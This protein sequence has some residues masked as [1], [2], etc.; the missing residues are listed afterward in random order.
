MPMLTHEDFTI[1]LEAA[2]ALRREREGI[3]ER[4][5]KDHLKDKHSQKKK[6]GGKG[7]AVERK[8]SKRQLRQRERKGDVL[9]LLLPPSKKRLYNLIRCLT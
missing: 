1:R 5:G 4:S 2:M 3:A 8:I 9:P 7:T 6:F